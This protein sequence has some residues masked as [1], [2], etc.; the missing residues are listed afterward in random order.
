MTPMVVVTNVGKTFRRYH[1]D[2]PASIQEA[3]AKGLRRMRT[4]E[5]VW[6]LRDVS[7]TVAAGKAVGIIG[8]NGSGKST[9]L[10]LIGGV[11]RPD[12]GRIDVHGAIGAL[13]DLGA[14]FHPELTGRENALLGGI[15]NGLT[16]RQTLERLDS[17]VAFAEVEKAIDN[18][19]RT[20][21]SGMQMRLA[22]SVAVHTEP[23]IL[24]IDEVLSVGDIAFQRKC[25]DRIAEFRARGCSILLVSHE[26]SVVQDLCDEAV[27]LS[28]GRLMAQ[29]AAAD[30]VRQYATHMGLGDSP[31]VEPPPPEEDSYPVAS[32]P[33][34][35]VRTTSGEEVAVDEQRFGS[36][37]LQ[38][39]TVRLRDADGQAVTELASGRALQIEIAYLA[40]AR[41]VAPIFYTRIERIDGLLCCDLNTEFSPLSLSTIDGAGTIRLHVERLDLNSGQYSFEVGCYAQGW[42][43]C[44]DR[45]ASVCELTIHG[46]GLTEAVLDVPHRW[47]T[48]PMAMAKL[49][50]ATEAE[51]GPPSA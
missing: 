2:R 40:I 26:G 15:L 24:L 36:V 35:I 50:G 33:P 22:F 16:R 39:G 5:R 51:T 41:L 1:A 9:L 29:G 31:P 38:I 19:M 46:E 25:M 3:V 14:G 44:Y 17:I 47:E 6:S 48:S 8:A 18:P 34:V 20:Y 12:T 13:L 45:R 37:E 32:P 21:S 11:G 43:Y 10:R 42:A 28:G 7:F 4:V 49:P 27:W 30:V 23:D